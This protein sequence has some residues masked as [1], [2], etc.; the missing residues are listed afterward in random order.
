MVWVCRLVLPVFR[1][2]FLVVVVV[3]CLEAGNASRYTP[4]PP[5]RHLRS[6]P[7]YMPQSRPAA[8][9]PFGHRHTGGAHAWEGGGWSYA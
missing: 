1:C 9:L 5:P 7:S 2:V 4:P 8:G 3:V 6:P